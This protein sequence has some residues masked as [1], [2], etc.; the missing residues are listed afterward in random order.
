ME[1]RKLIWSS[2]ASTCLNTAL[3]IRTRCLEVQWLLNVI[4]SQRA[5]F[6]VK[7]IDAQKDELIWLR[8]QR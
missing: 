1:H 4:D 6:L 3:L 7:V 5:S 8:S 2:P